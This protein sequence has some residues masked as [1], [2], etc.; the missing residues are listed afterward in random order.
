MA[1]IQRLKNTEGVSFFNR[2]L[3]HAFLLLTTIVSYSR[4]FYLALRTIRQSRI[5]MRLPYPKVLDIPLP[6]S[7]LYSL[8]TTL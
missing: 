5:L 7:R 8:L 2:K 3:E 1:R 4:L 6:S